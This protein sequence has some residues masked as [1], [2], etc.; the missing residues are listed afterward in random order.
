MLQIPDPTP[1]TKPV[2]LFT[3]ATLALSDVRVGMEAMR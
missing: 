2:P 1:V 3:V